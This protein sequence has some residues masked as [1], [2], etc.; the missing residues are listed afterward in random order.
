[1]PM[2]VDPQ[3]GIPIAPSV[4]P[5]WSIGPDGTPI[6]PTGVPHPEAA[7]GVAA[8]SVPFPL[9]STAVGAGA[10]YFL[11]KDKGKGK[12]WAA[13]GAAAGFLLRPLG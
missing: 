11:G 12:L 10:G 1:M 6:D 3:S 2:P 7:G 9:T 13:L 8:T 4:P 5:G